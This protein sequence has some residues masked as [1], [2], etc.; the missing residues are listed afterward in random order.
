MINQQFN[1][2]PGRVFANL[3]EM[4]KKDP[5]NERPRYK[6]PGKRA[7]DDSQMFEN[8][9]EARGFWR[10][11][12]EERGTGN[13]NA[14]WLQEVKMAIHEQVTKPTGDEW[15]VKEA[16]MVKALSKMRSW[17][18]PGPDKTTNFWWKRAGTLYKGLV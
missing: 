18:A 10:K 4:L 2:V 15:A 16:E 12:G 13:K 3:S 6:D 14:A 7:R 5:E 11:L 17:N 1:T 9:E 8:I